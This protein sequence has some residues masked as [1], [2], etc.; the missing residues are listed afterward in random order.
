MTAPPNGWLFTGLHWVSS[1][2]L[3]TAITQ[4]AEPGQVCREASRAAETGSVISWR[5]ALPRRC[6]GVWKSRAGGRRICPFA[7]QV[8]AA[9]FSSQCEA[10]AA[11]DKGLQMARDTALGDDGREYLLYLAWF[12]PGLVK[13]GLTAADRGRDRLLDQGAIAF[14]PLASGPYIP[15]RQAER[16]TAAS[17]LAS[18]RVSGRA[19]VAAWWTLPPAAERAALLAAAR[20]Q[21]LSAVSWPG[22]VQVQ[23]CSVTDQARDFGLDLFTPHDYDEVTSLSDGAVLAGQIRLVA[24]RYLILDTPGGLLLTDMR[25]AAGWTFR[26]EGPA[27]QLGGLSLTTRTPPREHHDQTATLF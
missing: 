23:P 16:R 24:G 22:R 18:E 13:V 1:K 27:A 17:G 12:G 10:G 2:P 21:I 4:P 5:L 19:K 25:R 11:D 26:A 7:S 9:G 20:D 3:L 6:T 8:P 14:T 15:I